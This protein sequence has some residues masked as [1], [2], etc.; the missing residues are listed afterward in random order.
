MWDPTNIQKILILRI[1]IRVAQKF[2]KVWMSRK[3]LG[4]LTRIQDLFGR[5]IMKF[6]LKWVHMARYELI[7]K[8]DR[9][10]WLRIILTPF[11]APKEA[12]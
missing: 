7:L 4:C 2:C 3:N 10:I 11:L 12:I 8:Q 1:K 6:D 5:K 9:A